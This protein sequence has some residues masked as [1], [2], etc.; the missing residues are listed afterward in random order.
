V[1]DIIS[2]AVL[3]LIYLQEQKRLPN[4]KSIKTL[5][6]ISIYSQ[7]S[8][9]V[10]FYGEVLKH[11]DISE[12]NQDKYELTN[13]LVRSA[14]QMV[15]DIVKAYDRMYLDFPQIYNSCAGKFGRISAVDQKIKKT[16]SVPFLTTSKKTDYRYSPAFFLPLFCGIRCL[17]YI[18]EESDTL[19]WRINP[20]SE[21]FKFTSLDC[22]KY[23][24]MIKFL[25]YNPLKV[26]KA[27]MMYLEGVDIFNA[28]LNIYN[29]PQNS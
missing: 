1:E 9:C 3:P 19:K 23:I 26:G 4:G 18:D 8:K 13:N 29:R 5:S 22:S 24:E 12:K 2:I 28:L 7:K 11:S 20:A 14:L 10:D 17:M 27:N 16:V 15:G 25:D 6:P 21:S